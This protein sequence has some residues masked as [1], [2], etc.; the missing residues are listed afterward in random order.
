M[1]RPI[2]G[3]VAVALLAGCSSEDSA[4][5]QW[6]DGVC[7]AWNELSSDLRG[8][9]D[10]LNVD[11]LSPEALDQLS[12]EITE[13]VDAVQ[14][15]AENLAEAIADTPEGADQAVESAQQELGDEAGDVRAG[16]DA[17]G[18]A[19][20]SLSGATTGQDITSAL[21]DAQAALTQT[22]QALGTLGDTVAGYVSAADDTLRQA[23]DDA[24]SCQ[25][26]HTGGTSS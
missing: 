9:T 7:S 19:V 8:V 1:R 20:Q 24:Q 11:S 21:S 2:L 16:L 13:R 22:G 14:A 4:E 10:G 12:S 26:T 25:Q 6:A 5:T 3:L 17:T 18:Q 15:S 23:F